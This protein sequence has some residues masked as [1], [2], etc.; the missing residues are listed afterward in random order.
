MDITQRKGGS[1]VTPKTVPM[2]GSF[3]VYIKW[4]VYAWESRLALVGACEV[5]TPGYLLT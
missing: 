3:V 2:I 4:C 1:T 5:V